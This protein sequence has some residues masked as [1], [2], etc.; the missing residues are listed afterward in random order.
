MIIGRPSI[1]RKFRTLGGVLAIG[2]L[3]GAGVL[4]VDALTGKSF[5]TPE[6][7]G[8]VLIWLMLLLIWMVLYRAYRQYQDHANVCGPRSIDH[9]PKSLNFSPTI[10]AH[11]YKIH[12]EEIFIK[13]GFTEA[14]K[15]VGLLVLTGM[16]LEEI[17]NFRGT[18]LKTVKNQ[19][20][21]I[22]EKAQVKNGKELMSHFIQRLLI[23]PKEPS[24]EAPARPQ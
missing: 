23:L 17:A 22:Y 2:L 1:Y 13:W 11:G 7:Y 21:V 15:E 24:A 14:E 9:L 5:A 20:T 10:W 19:T 6:V 12:F 4:L 18:S 3:I 16:P 8:A